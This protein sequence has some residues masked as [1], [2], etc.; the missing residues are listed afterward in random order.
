MKG[1]FLSGHLG[2]SITHFFS[3]LHFQ[4]CL[5]VL[6]PGDYSFSVSSTYTTY[7]LSSS[8]SPTS[9]SCL[10]HTIPAQISTPGTS[11]ASHR[12]ATPAVPSYCFSTPMYRHCLFANQD[13]DL[14]Q[15]TARPLDL[16]AMPAPQSPHNKDARECEKDHHSLGASCPIRNDKTIVYVPS[17]GSICEE[18]KE[19]G[20]KYNALCTLH[21][22]TDKR[23]VGNAS[24]IE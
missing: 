16:A 2:W 20:G 10:A 6:M 13:S 5:T 14:K 19:H 17:K 18:K 21:Q 11:S 1:W 15:A 22:G 23:N 12:S 4:Y 7:T 9:P 3:V 24:M 8:V